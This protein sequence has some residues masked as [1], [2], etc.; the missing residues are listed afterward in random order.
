MIP[1]N[2]EPGM[3]GRDHPFGHGIDSPDTGE[4]V[5]VTSL[6]SER[7][8]VQVRLPALAARNDVLDRQALGHIQLRRLA[9]LTSATRPSMNLPSE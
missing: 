5:I 7:E 9:I 3:I 2:V 4:L 8:I 6:A 1:P